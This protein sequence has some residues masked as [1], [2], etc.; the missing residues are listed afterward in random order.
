MLNNSLDCLQTRLDVKVQI[1][2]HHFGFPHL[3]QN[4]PASGGGEWGRSQGCGGVWVG[5]VGTCRKDSARQLGTPL[6]CCRVCGYASSPG[7]KCSGLKTGNNFLQ[8][9]LYFSTPVFSWFQF[10]VWSQRRPGRS[11]K[12]MSCS[13]KVGRG[14]NFVDLCFLSKN[15]VLGDFR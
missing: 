14:R 8:G 4:L 12:K 7:W 13:A 9:G 2:P 10:T 3:L 11:D 15:G 1:I 6:D 5:V